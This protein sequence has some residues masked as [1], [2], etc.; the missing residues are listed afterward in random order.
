MPSHSPLDAL[1]QAILLA[2]AGEPAGLGI[3]ALEEALSGRLERVV[4]RRTL[5]R[6]LAALHRH[7]YVTY[8]GASVARA[9]PERSIASPTR[10][11]ICFSIPARSAP[12]AATT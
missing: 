1:D 5:Q 3:A 12:S 10:S 4:Q 2:L 8:S 9:M 7:G 11:T 6:R